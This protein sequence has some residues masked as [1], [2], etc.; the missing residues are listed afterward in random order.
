MYEEVPVKTP[1]VATAA[2]LA[3]VIGIAST[4]AKEFTLR[5]SHPKY[6]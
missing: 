2:E 4:N 5:Y 6:I 3:T 1:S